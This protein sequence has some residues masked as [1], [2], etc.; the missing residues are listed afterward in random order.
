MVDVAILDH[1]SIIALLL[2]VLI[3]LPHGALDGAIAMH[4]GAGRSITS[5]LQFLFLYLLCSVAVVLIW[6]KFSAF[7]LSIFLII[8][9]VHFGWGDANSK[10]SLLFFLQMICH[11]GIVVFGIVY[12][13]VDEVIPLFDMLTGGNSRLPI[14]VS[15]YMFYGISFFTILY[16]IFLFKTRSLILRF[17]EL[18]ILWLIVII[19][20]PLL[21]FAVYFCFV[22]T[23][24]H[25][26][27]IWK[28][29]KVEISPK[30]IITQASILTLS[31]WVL[32]VIA[33]YAFDSG[34]FNTNIIR[35]VFIGLAA[36][37][38]PHMILVDGFFRNK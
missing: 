34:D 29:L 25:I 27:N 5:V 16:F 11:G 36:L 3:G 9:M 14:Q 30:V 20:P 31:S 33:L 17:L 4:L 26:R 2:I 12:F 18:A 32:G 35:V 7:S 1:S 10:T 19:F 28:E 23:A 37:T 24:R 21:G 13:H 15:V 38:V 22:H 8:S 6:Y